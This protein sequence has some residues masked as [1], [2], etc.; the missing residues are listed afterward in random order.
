MICAT[1]SN[2]ADKGFHGPENHRD[3][4]SRV[5]KTRCDCQHKRPNRTADEQQ[6]QRGSSQSNSTS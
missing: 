4:P 6:G 5:N 2:A 3:C 1:C